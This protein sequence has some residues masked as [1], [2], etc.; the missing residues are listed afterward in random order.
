MNS[1]I[2]RNKTIKS[3]DV[4]AV[5]VFTGLDVCST[6]CGFNSRIYESIAY[7]YIGSIDI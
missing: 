4:A 1:L 7:M 5:A 2:E 6:D 3:I